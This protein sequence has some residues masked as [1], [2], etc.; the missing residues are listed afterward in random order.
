M[1]VEVVHFVFQAEPSWPDA[2]WL[3]KQNLNCHH[4]I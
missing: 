2:L 4:D 1:I 3:L